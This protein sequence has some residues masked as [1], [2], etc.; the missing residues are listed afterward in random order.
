MVLGEEMERMR[1]AA[2]VELL[3]LLLLLL[4]LQALQ[5]LLLL[6]LLGLHQ[7][8]CCQLVRPEQQSAWGE[9]CACS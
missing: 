1:L 9:Y 6:H 3:L 4:L 2:V 7:H 5:P 8:H